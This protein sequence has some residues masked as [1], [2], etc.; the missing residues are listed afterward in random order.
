MKEFAVA[1]ASHIIKRSIRLTGT[2]HCSVS[3]DISRTVRASGRAFF[4]IEGG[5]VTKE[6]TWAVRSTLS[7]REWNY[8]I[9]IFLNRSIFC[10]PIIVISHFLLHIVPILARITI[11]GIGAGVTTVWA[12]ITGVGSVI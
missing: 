7:S 6:T 5:L 4:T 2:A 8:I 10:S 12:S 1:I 3:I 9:H 11:S